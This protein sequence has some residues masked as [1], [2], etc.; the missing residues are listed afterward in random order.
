MLVLAVLAVGLCWESAVAFSW[1][2]GYRRLF[3]AREANANG[4]VVL[5]DLSPSQ[6]DVVRRLNGGR[7]RSFL[8]DA[9]AQCNASYKLFKW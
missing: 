7:S 4:A 2:E 3:L 5:V 8:A 1:V 6:E 9:G